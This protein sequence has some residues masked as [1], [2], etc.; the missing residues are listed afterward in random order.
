VQENRPI[1]PSKSMLHYH[2]LRY[3]HRSQLLLLQETMRLFK[4]SISLTPIQKHHHQVP[5]QVQYRS[6]PLHAQESYGGV[7]RSNHGMR[8][9]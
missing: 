8:I 3:L 6:H 5:L 9:L 4:I 7:P 2:R 1:T